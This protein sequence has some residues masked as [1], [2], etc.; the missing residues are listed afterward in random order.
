MAKMGQQM[1]PSG[2]QSA[3]G[4]DVEEDWVKEITN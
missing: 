3:A 4:H 2:A 1:L